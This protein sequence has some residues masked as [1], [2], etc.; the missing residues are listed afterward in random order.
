MSVEHDIVLVLRDRSGTY[1][2]Q[3]VQAPDTAY[4][5][6]VQQPVLAADAALCTE[7]YPALAAAAR[8]LGAEHQAISARPTTSTVTTAA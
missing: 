4:R 7:G 8:Y 2:D 1:T 5:A 3:I 6:A